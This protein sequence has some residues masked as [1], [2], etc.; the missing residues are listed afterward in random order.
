M[1]TQ[2]LALVATRIFATGIQALTVILLARWAGVRDFGVI[3]VIVGICAVLY[4]IADWGLSS[5]IPRARA[6]GRNSEVVSGLRMDFLGN[7]SLGLLAALVL[8]LLL[9]PAGLTAWFVLIPLA[10]ALEQFVE[11]CLTVPIADGNKGVFVVSLALRRVVSISLFVALYTL[12]WDVI[13]SYGIALATAS[14]AGLAHAVVVLRRRLRGV[15]SNVRIGA[16]YKSLVPY[17]LA[18]LSAQSRTLD[19][20]VV[21]AVSSVISAGLYSAAFRLINPLM[22]VSGSLAAVL[23]PHAAKQGM[24][25]TKR[26]GRSLALC[27][28]ALGILVIPP[29]AYAGPLVEALFGK[30]FAAAAPAFAFALAALPFLSLSSPLGGLLQSQGFESFVA[31]NGMTFAALNLGLVCLGAAAWG[32]TGAAAAIAIAYA[33]KCLSLYVRLQTAKPKASGPRGKGAG[34]AEGSGAEGADASELRMV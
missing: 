34:G 13:A 17:L 15:R 4:T 29:I 3:G 10:L 27:T 31:K 30:D 28:L 16:Y 25:E 20:A 14:C 5:Y 8:G 32:P 12:G 18:N 19:T 7:C 21:G 2:F 1:K 6:V 33:G 9:L 26:L 23:L 11:V 22:L 24:P